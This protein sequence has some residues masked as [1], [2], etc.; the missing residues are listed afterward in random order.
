MK[1]ILFIL[2]GTFFIINCAPFKGP[3]GDPGANGESIVGPKGETGS[4]GQIGPRGLDGQIAK[5]VQLCPGTSNYGVFIETA[6]CINN[7]LYGVYSTNGGFL[8]Y[9]APGTYSS[10]GVGSACNFKVESNCV[11]SPL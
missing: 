7:S 9:L 5:V 10:N 4:P 8:T 1:K 11:V 3:K 6:L 2:I